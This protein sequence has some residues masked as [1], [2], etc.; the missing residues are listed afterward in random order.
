VPA[1]VGFFVPY[2]TVDA[3]VRYRCDAELP[4]ERVDPHDEAL[5]EEPFQVNQVRGHRDFGRPE[6]NQGAG[7][8]NQCA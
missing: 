8:R 7:A 6:E 4:V 2:P 3:Y 1:F 5:L